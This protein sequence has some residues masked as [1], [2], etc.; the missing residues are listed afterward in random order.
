M[1][2][3]SFW[4][5]KPANNNDATTAAKEQFEDLGA[6]AHTV[7]DSIREQTSS[8][9]DSFKQISS[10]SFLNALS[11]PS[12]LLATAVLTTSILTLLALQRRFLKRYPTATSLPETF[13][14]PSTKRFTRSIFGHV[15]SIGDAD[16]FRLYHT[17]LGRLALWGFLRRIPDTPKELKNNTIHIRLAGIDA[18]EL[19]HFGRPAQPYSKEALE[20][21]T[22]YLRGRRVRCYVH[23]A[24][25]YSRVVATVYVRQGLLRRDVS[26]QM[27]RA[28][29]ATMYESKSGAEFSGP[30]VEER[31]RAVEEVAKRRKK[32]MWREENLESPREYKNRY[33]DGGKE[34]G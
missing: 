12:T 14:L 17:P 27:L 4:S 11:Q 21:L 31:Y 30:G 7:A 29:L 1:P 18:P 33:K 2:W 34:G 15:T 13:L 16:N 9:T 23:K 25:Q 5:S 22:N 6:K 20:W 26:L 10:N 32:G 8:T 28:G 3:P 24:D 19:A